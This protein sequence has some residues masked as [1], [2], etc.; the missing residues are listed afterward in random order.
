[1]ALQYMMSN[2][3]K[4]VVTVREV[5]DFH[6]ISQTLLA[7]ILQALARGRIIESVQGSQGGYTLVQN[8]KKI[9]LAKIMEAIEGPIHITDCYYDP[10]CCLRSNFCTLRERLA[11]VQKGLVQHL[12]NI[13]MADFIKE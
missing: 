6:N 1:M 5:A 7:K 10:S 11:P 2:A 9:S 13:T 8:V 4:N 3:D 12:Q